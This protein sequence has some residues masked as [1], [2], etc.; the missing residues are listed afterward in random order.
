MPQLFWPSAPQ[1]GGILWFWH[2][3]GTPGHSETLLSP[4]LVN[5]SPLYRQVFL[6]PRVVDVS[7]FFVSIDC[8]VFNTQGFQTTPVR[9]PCALPIEKKWQTNQ[10]H[11]LLSAN[12]LRNP[13]CVVFQ[14]AGSAGLA[15][16]LTANHQRP[17][18][19]PLLSAFPWAVSEG[20]ATTCDRGTPG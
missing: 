6:C 14:C 11:E 1:Q 3:S 12:L 2:C 13:G 7:L 15:M 18:S 17:P 5:F 16:A 19:N 10:T 4:G 20:D 8:F 9:S